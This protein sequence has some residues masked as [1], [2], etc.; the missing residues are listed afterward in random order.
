MG[1]SASASAPP[2]AMSEWAPD[3]SFASALSPD[4]SF[5]ERRGTKLFDGDM[6]YRAIGANRPDLAAGPLAQACRRDGDV[7]NLRRRQLGTL[8]QMRKS[9]AQVARLWAFQSMAGPNGDDF[10]HIDSLIDVAH[11]VGIALVLVLENHYP[12]CSAGSRVK[13][14]AWYAGG[15]ARPY[16]GYRRSFEDY[17]ADIT[18]RYAN[19]SA[20]LMW[21]IINE[22]QVPGRPEVVR[23]FLAHMARHIR[24]HDRVHLVAGGGTH[25][26]GESDAT[27]EF[28]V[29]ADAPGIDVLD[30]HDFGDERSA[31]SACMADAKAVADER[32]LLVMVGESGVRGDDKSPEARARLMQRKVVAAANHGVGIYLLWSWSTA[33][34]EKNPFDVV[35]GEPMVDILQQESSMSFAMRDIEASEAL[36]PD[37]QAWGAD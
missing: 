2:S 21:Q 20:I 17:V 25:A 15:F 11:E 19:E 13:D 12:E 6:V 26:C 35:M 31:W 7:D 34:D 37:G 24:R 1:C 33:G 28:A 22:A 4:G 3:L 36:W 14:G 5:V 30:V 27:H 18:H 10:S 23:D 9:G 8:Y 29:M 16:G 32:G